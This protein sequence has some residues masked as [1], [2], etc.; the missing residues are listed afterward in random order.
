MTGNPLARSRLANLCAQRYKAHVQ[1]R[2]R[3]RHCGGI[4]ICTLPLFQIAL[5]HLGLPST[6]SSLS[7][8]VCL[9]IAQTLVHRGDVELI[10]QPVLRLSICD[11]EEFWRILREF[12]SSSFSY[13]LSSNA[14]ALASCRIEC[15]RRIYSRLLESTRADV[16][17][18]RL[19]VNKRRAG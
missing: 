13:R 12:V 10:V 15:I 18:Q 4:I 9:Q 6:P 14:F 8:S 11:P 19:N 5:V 7:L 1:A 3:R 17:Y 16:D 2:T